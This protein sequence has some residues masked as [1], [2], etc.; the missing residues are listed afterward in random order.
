MGHLALVLLEG[1][2]ALRAEHQFASEVPLGLECGE[3]VAAERE[4]AVASA[5]RRTHVPPPVAA[6]TTSR[7]ATRSTSSQRS[8]RS[9]PMRSPVRSAS[10]NIGRHS[11]SAASRNRSASSKVRK[12]N[13]GCGPLSQRTLGTCEGSSQSTATESA[14]RSMDDAWLQ[15]RQAAPAPRAA[16]ADRGRHGQLPRAHRQAQRTVPRA[17]RETPRGTGFVRMDCGER[18]GTALAGASSFSRCRSS[19]VSNLPQ[20]IEVPDHA[21]IGSADPPWCSR[22]RVRDALASV[23]CPVPG[24]VRLDRWERRN[25]RPV[26]RI[27]GSGSKSK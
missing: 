9:S 2:A 10:V 24:R 16:T 3:D 15:R 17:G 4:L 19:C 11:G 1:A 22:R 6:R 14:S 27:I 18:D 25:R 7:P 8:A 12:S 26:G 20:R 21:R 13:S 23:G 5:L